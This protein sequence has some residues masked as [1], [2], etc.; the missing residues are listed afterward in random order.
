MGSLGDRLDVAAPRDHLGVG[1]ETGRE[2]ATSVL[3]SAAP[4]GQ[5]HRGH[6]DH[7]AYPRAR[8][9][10]TGRLEREPATDGI[11]G[12]RKSPGNDRSVRVRKGGL[13]AVLGTSAARASVGQTDAGRCGPPSPR[14]RVPSGNVGPGIRPGDASGQLE[15]IARNRVRS[16]SA[17]SRLCSCRAREH[18]TPRI[19]QGFPA[20]ATPRRRRSQPPARPATH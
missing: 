17:Q 12:H 5:D 10:S 14:G 1:V 9:E 20:T 3:P 7:G 16:K 4:R 8:I 6:P 19:S 13:A 15:Q 2:G 11:V 18:P